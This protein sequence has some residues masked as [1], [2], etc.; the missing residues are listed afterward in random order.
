MDGGEALTLRLAWFFRVAEKTEKVGRAGEE[1]TEHSGVS[2]GCGRTQE[3]PEQSRGRP[4]LR[5]PEILSGPRTLAKENEAEEVQRGERRL[6]EPSPPSHSAP[7]RLEGRQ[8]HGFRTFGISGWRSS[9]LALLPSQRRESRNASE[10][11]AFIFPGRSK[12]SD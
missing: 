10:G 8:H 2:S 6:P 12:C 9:R 4:F 1:G 5:N 11:L 3:R 7:L